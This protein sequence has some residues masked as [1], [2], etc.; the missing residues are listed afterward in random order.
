MVVGEGDGLSHCVDDLGA[1]A[2]KRKGLCHVAMGRGRL[3]V[4]WGKAAMGKGGTCLDW[5]RGGTCLDW[6]RGKAVTRTW[7]WKGL[8]A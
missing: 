2:A 1:V 5:K 4:A 3:S 6:K 7:A 8:I